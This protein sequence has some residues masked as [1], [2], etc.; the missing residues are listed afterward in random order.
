MVHAREEIIKRH[1]EKT[2]AN[3]RAYEARSRSFVKP[4]QNERQHEMSKRTRSTGGYRE[5]EKKAQIE[6]PDSLYSPRI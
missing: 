3:Q 6:E 5:R 4:F 1:E 2:D